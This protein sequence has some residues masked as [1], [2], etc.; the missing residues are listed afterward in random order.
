MRNC[1]GLRGSRLAF[2][3]TLPRFPRRP[4]GYSLVRKVS[5]AAA[6]KAIMGIL[7]RVT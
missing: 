7:I 3:G 5:Q 1:Q 4:L 2:L 6:E